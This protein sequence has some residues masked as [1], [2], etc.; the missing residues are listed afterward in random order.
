MLRLLTSFAL[1]TA[2]LTPL[3]AQRI[4]PSFSPS[5]LPYGVSYD[6]A[7]IRDF[8][9]DGFVDILV[10]EYSD[11]DAWRLAR[12]DGNGVI[13][14]LEVV[15]SPVG[16]SALREMIVDFDGDGDLDVGYETDA[17]RFIA[18]NDG[19]GR[20]LTSS[21]LSLL[22]GWG[23]AAA[24]DI[25]GDGDADIVTYGGPS[26]Q[27]NDIATWLND[28]SG[29]F[30]AGTE[31][32]GIFVFAWPVNQLVDIDGDG[33]LD[34]MS[35]RVWE[36][37]GSGNFSDVTA[38]RFAVGTPPRGPHAFADF[39]GDGFTDL[40]T[41]IEL[42]VNDGTGLLVSTL[43]YN[44][45]L[46]PDVEAF[47]YEGDGDLDIFVPIAGTGFPMLL[48]NDGSASFTTETPSLTGFGAGWV[49][50]VD[51]DGDSDVDLIGPPRTLFLGN[52]QGEFFD[53]APRALPYLTGEFRESIAGDVD[54]DGDV[55]VLTRTETEFQVH[56][57]DGLG[58]FVPRPP[59][60]L[61]HPD[62]NSGPDIEFGDFDN[63]GNLDFAYDLVIYEGDG[64]G[65]FTFAFEYT[66]WFARSM[67]V[68][69]FDG[70][71]DDD[72]AWSNGLL[73]HDGNFS[74]SL[75][76]SPLGDSLDMAS[77]DIDGDGDLDVCSI[78]AGYPRLFSNDGNG[79]FTEITAVLPTPEFSG[80]GKTVTIV[81]VDD[82]SDL[83]IFIGS[84]SF[85]WE[86]LWLFEN[87]GNGGFTDTT[88][89]TFGTTPFCK[90]VV[91][92]DFDLD[93]DT[94]VFAIGTIRIFFER[95]DTG[96]ISPTFQWIG[97]LDNFEQSPL[98]ADFDQDGDLDVLMERYN[99][100]VEIYHNRRRQLLAPRVGRTG[101]EIV[102][103][104]HVETVTT[105]TIYPFVALS[106]FDPAI[107]TPWGPLH[108]DAGAAITLPPQSATVQSPVEWEFGIPAVPS[109]VGLELFSQALFV[110]S[111]DASTWR[112]SNAIR[113]PIVE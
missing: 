22:D 53:A 3:T 11:P 17:G 24:G 31:F 33:D 48:R 49:T 56:L 34:F 46:S 19:G 51:V 59:F 41:S 90:D 57:N 71:G 70:D 63:D 85:S 109:I 108:A 43:S 94:D 98:A 55:D 113:H 60:P 87:D 68:G 69:D 37:D 54:N 99:F 42:F 7:M 77:G 88:V 35:N 25:D 32:P 72:I 30:T 78:V 27:F 76:S 79:N 64:A 65:G 74:F 106:R 18:W 75:L 93:G 91:V 12:N 6:P 107:P 101:S 2:I 8:D 4:T 92:A 62:Y 50:V 28:G 86:N 61:P 96:F 40:A 39:N 23:D 66:A 81:D 110:P 9:G 95:T 97:A 20:F 111:V 29:N 58:Q 38:A 47:D 26:P 36:N 89:A 45:A 104:G 52:G 105:E 83:D 100:G 14:E 1:G 73:R 102:L 5:Q 112:L 10:H 82:D 21:S 15:P 44:T 103:R 16:A 67:T 84:R 13:A 80:F